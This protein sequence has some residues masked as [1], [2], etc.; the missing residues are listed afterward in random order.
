MRQIIAP[1]AMLVLAACGGASASTSTELSAVQVE[2]RLRAPERVALIDVRTA[3]EFAAGHIAGARNL[4]VT[5]PNF[6][7]A[8]AGLPKDRPYILYCRSGRRSANAQAIMTKAGFVNV[9]NMSG[10][11]VAWEAAGLP[12]R[13]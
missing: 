9:Q 2:Q 1:F 6:E 5:A 4:D 10:G 3:D 7:A 11:L 13:K 8:L 12:T